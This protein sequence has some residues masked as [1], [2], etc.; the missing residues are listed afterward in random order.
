MFIDQADLFCRTSRRFIRQIMEME[1]RVAYQKGERV[2]NEGDPAE[3]FFVLL[4]G[5]VRLHIGEEGQTVHMVSNP[6]EGFGWSCLVNRPVFSATAE[7]T[8][9]TTLLVFDQ[10]HF[11]Q[12]I[13]REPADGLIFYRNLAQLL[14][15]R[16]LLSYQRFSPDRGGH[17]VGTGQ[18]QQVE[19][20]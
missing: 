4:D 11:R 9:P 8:A 3:C 12:I 13:E 14:G 15:H 6:G 16:L 17:A 7:C 2:F 20:L 1:R 5:C 18:F 10:H 19:A